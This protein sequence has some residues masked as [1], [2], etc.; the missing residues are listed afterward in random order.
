MSIQ[1]TDL[2]AMTDHLKALGLAPGVDVV[3]HSSLMAFGRLQP[4]EGQSGP[5]MVYQAARDL[6]GPEATLVAPSYT[7]DT[8]ERPYDVRHSAS[9]GVGALS[10]YVRQRPD[11]VRSLSPV[12][13]H[14][15]VG[16]KAEALLSDTPPDVSLGPRS[17]FERLRE[18]DLLLVLLGVG[19]RRGCTYLH[20]MEAVAEVPY[21]R[22]LALPRVVINADGDRQVI[23]MRYFARAEDP[24][25]RSWRANFD[26]I[27]DDLRA[28]G[29][30]TEVQAPYG[31]SYAVRLSDLHR[32]AEALLSADP[33]AL[34]A[35]ITAAEITG[36]ESTGAESTEGAG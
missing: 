27:V 3:I 18:A 17:D 34:V 5:E 9:T 11:A 14:V 12:H 33:Y 30:L 35:E 36:A 16:P 2:A 8:H 26:V 31:V 15:A 29:A 13:N 20:H 22:W 28:D 25:G 19:F 24:E 10:E 7:F 21:R 32:R 1:I 23:Q 4:P 6:I